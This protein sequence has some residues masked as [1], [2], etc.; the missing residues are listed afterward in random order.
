VLELAEAGKTRSNIVAESGQ[1]AVAV[2]RILKGDA[3]P[4]EYKRS[5]ATINRYLAT[6]SHALTFA[7]KA[8]KLITSYPIEDIDRKKGVARPHTVPFG[9]RTRS[10]VGCLCE[11]RLG[12]ATHARVACDHH[13]CPSR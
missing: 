6:L 3:A 4:K 1:S 12:G 13:G 5:G 8:R 9:R 7:K 10:A 2:R 11:V